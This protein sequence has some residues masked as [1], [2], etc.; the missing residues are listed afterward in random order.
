MLAIH[1][2]PMPAQPEFQCHSLFPPSAPPVKK[3]PQDIRVPWTVFHN[4]STAGP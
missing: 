3:R 1:S 2:L 4:C